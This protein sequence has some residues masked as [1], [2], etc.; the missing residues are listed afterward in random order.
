MGTGPSSI[1]ASYK[2]FDTRHCTGSSA[3]VPNGSGISAIETSGPNNMRYALAGS[4][5]EACYFTTLDA[6]GNVLSTMAYPFPM[7]QSEASMVYAKPILVESNVANEYFICGYFESNMYVIK[8]A[9]NGSILWSSFYTLGNE[10]IPKDII[11]SPYRSGQL[12][13]VGETNISPQDNQGFFMTIDGSSGN[14]TS[15]KLFG[16]TDKM[17]GFGSIV[18]GAFVN[19]GN[20]KGFVIGGYTEN[21]RDQTVSTPWILKLDQ[22]GNIIW[23]KV[24]DP[25]VGS[26]KGIIDLVERLNTFGGYE[27][28]ALTTSHLGMQVL[29]LDEEGRPFPTL[30]SSSLH[31]E[32]VY[33][34]PSLNP[35]HANSI[36]YANTAAIT[37]NVGIQVFGTASNFAGFSSSYLVNAYFN[38]ETNCYRSL[39]KMSDPIEGPG[40]ITP[41][42]PGKFGSFT[43]C[44]NFYVYAYFSGGSTNTPCYGPMSSGSNLRIMS[45]GIDPQD[46]TNENFS[47][48]PNPISDRATVNYTSY[49]NS[50]ISINV[51]NLL[52][53]TIVNVNLEQGLAGSYQQEI[54]FTSLNVQS[55]VYFVN[56]TVDGKLHKQKVI[57]TK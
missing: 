14:A 1:W 40:E 46:Q 27:Y 37:A 3:Q 44:S 11:M 23:N 31:N 21:P 25:I 50:K 2:I 13:V 9:A 45:S 20:D 28:Y 8:V 24:L 55:G 54:D 18:G 5:D 32:F 49:D 43:A 16:Y 30:T 29:K 17:D 22:L 57:Y 15:T 19:S 39:N 51:S 12:I 56:T 4:Y 47:V 36:S 7:L 41:L 26:T 6:S 52:G 42:E 34:L 10:V 48:S 53:Q 33:D 38:G 35:S